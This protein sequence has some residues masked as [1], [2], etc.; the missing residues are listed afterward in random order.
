[1]RTRTIRSALLLLAVV[2]GSLGGCLGGTSAPARFYALAPVVTPLSGGPAKPGPSLGIG[3]V[4]LPAYLDRPQIV[5]RQGPEELSLAEFERW[6]EPLKTGVPRVLADNLAVLLR[7]D[8]ISLFPWA[9]APAGQIQIAVDVTRFERVGGKE[10]A[11]NARWRLLTSDG[12]ELVARQAAIA[13]ATGGEGYDA[14]A[15]AMSRALGALSRDVA[16]AV[17]EL[18]Q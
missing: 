14:I 4:T 15:A 13:E 2:A 12:T 11:L 10:V 5:T 16:A 6:S 18:P 1:M 7:T 3:P 17:C 8:R 9:K